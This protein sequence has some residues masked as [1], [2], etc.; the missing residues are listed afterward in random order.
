MS[1]LIQ[2]WY[3]EQSLTLLKWCCAALAITI[4]WQSIGTQNGL[5]FKHA[6]QVSYQS[7]KPY[8]TQTSHSQRLK[9]LLEKEQPMFTSQNG[10]LY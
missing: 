2:W 3:S 1:L 4:M 6:E 8:L 7:A 10:P 9:N 5:H